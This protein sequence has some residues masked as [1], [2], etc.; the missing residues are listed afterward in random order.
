MGFK[1]VG[2]PQFENNIYTFLQTLALLTFYQEN[3]KLADQSRIKL[4]NLKIS[5]ISETT[6][7]G[8][9]PIADFK[10]LSKKFTIYHFT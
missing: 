7:K 3:T 5:D 4:S 8:E 6:P 9:T 1:I 2:L 10:K